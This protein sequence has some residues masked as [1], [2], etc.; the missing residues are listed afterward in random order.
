MEG[1]WV[2]APGKELFAAIERALGPLPIIAEDLG[3]ITPDVIELRD[4]CGFPGMK[5]LQFAF[6]GDGSHEFLPHNY[7]THCVVYTGTHD[8]ET[9]R[10]WWAHARPR[11]RAFA[12]A[13]LAAGDE[14]LHW[15]MIRAASNSV[16]N[17]A[18]FPL[19]DVLGLDASHRMNLPGSTEGNWAWRFEWRMVG[20]EPGRVLGLITAASGRGPIELLHLP[21]A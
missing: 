19:Q 18:V 12:G 3:L 5:I 7:G 1:T 20:N 2:P 21:G 14:D 9:A 17:M 11:E 4:G 10:G 13:Y 16:A 8:N 15:A 6:G